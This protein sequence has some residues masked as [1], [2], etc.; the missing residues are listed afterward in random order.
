ML[1]TAKEARR[2]TNKNLFSMFQDIND[3]ID[4]QIK[5]ATKKGEFAT[6]Y[7]N[8][9]FILGSLYKAL[10]DDL[11]LAG[12]EV[13]TSEVERYQAGEPNSEPAIII[14]SWDI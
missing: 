2:L 8:D 10:I 6:V 14:I 1:L 12:Y 3:A 13:D 11:N 9:R 7:K 4:R 5:E